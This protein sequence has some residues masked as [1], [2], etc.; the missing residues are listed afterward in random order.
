M[1]TESPT[2]HPAPATSSW[3]LEFDSFAAN[4][5]ST[6]TDE[7]V[8]VYK[9]G[10]GRTY[11]VTLFQE[12]CEIELTED[13][14][15]E[16]V[17]ERTRNVDGDLANE[18]LYLGMNVMKNA[19]VLNNVYKAKEEGADKTLDLCLNVELL[20]D[21]DGSTVKQDRQE[22][23]I[24]FDFENSFTVT[25][26]KNLTRVYVGSDSVTTQVLGYIEACTC[27]VTVNK[28]DFTC[29]TDVISNTGINSKLNVCIWS[30]S[31]DKME[32]DYLDRV[33]M[34]GNG[35]EMTIIEN[36]NP[37]DPNIHSYSEAPLWNGVYVESI[38]TAGFFSYEDDTTATITG[39][40]F[41]KLPGSRRRRVAIALT[42]HDE[43]ES[44][45][46][47]TIGYARDPLEQKSAFLVNVA[48]KKTGDSLELEL[49]DAANAAVGTL[50][51]R[52][53]TSTAI[54][55]AAVMIMW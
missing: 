16:V 53:I 36:S 12:G 44:S 11:D 5:N 3:L 34:E 4:F 48:L 32:I 13:D 24:T 27:D 54:T 45:R 41:L 42:G 52:F 55:A 20:S 17:S 30:S 2:A 18:W 38:V 40:V 29:N 26:D 6:S 33:V 49:D 19:T 21:S 28:D 25:P 35:Q 10:K 51:S 39:V 9:I 47:L 15:I 46:A 22:I 31:A 43:F 1:V 50:M 7:I 37:V 8:A 14:G 23:S